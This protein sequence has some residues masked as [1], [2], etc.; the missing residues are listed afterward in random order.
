MAVTGPNTR[1]R[2]SP[3]CETTL[4]EGVTAVSPYNSM[5]MLVSY[6]DPQAEYGG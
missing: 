3:Y 4:R 6:C 1:L 2:V 5:L